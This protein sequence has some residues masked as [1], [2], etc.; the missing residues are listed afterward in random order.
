MRATRGFLSFRPLR[1]F[2]CSHYATLRAEADVL[3]VHS[4]NLLGQRLHHVLA[5]L[6]LL[7][8]EGRVRATMRLDLIR[9]KRGQAVKRRKA[10]LGCLDAPPEA[11]PL[12]LGVRAAAAVRAQ[13]AVEPRQVE[14]RAED[15]AQLLLPSSRLVRVGGWRARRCFDGA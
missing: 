13:A 9:C 12:L 5:D 1:V 2:I 4:R 11:L 3:K 10:P 8:E 15:R 6:Q 14:V 7:R